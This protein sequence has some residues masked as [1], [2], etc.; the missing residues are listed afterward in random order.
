MTKRRNLIICSIFG[1]IAALSWIILLLAA[2]HT[3]SKNLHDLI[4]VIG[5]VF[6]M[7]VF[8]WIV[9][10]G[11]IYFDLDGW[12][13]Y[14][15]LYTTCVFLLVFGIAFLISTLVRMVVTRLPS[16]EESKRWRK[17]Y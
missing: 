2:D 3:N 14:Y 1:A 4:F 6:I 5:I 16:S 8:G 12:A 13:E 10:P 7:P 17:Y 9:G 15:V 11:I